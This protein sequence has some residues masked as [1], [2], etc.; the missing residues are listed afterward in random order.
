MRALLPKSD[1]AHE[2]V[3]AGIDFE[4]L[5]T[6]Y[7]A[8][9]AH[10]QAAEA[11]ENGDVALSF[12]ELVFEDFAVHHVLVLVDQGTHARSRA[13]VLILDDVEG[14]GAVGVDR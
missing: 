3:D 5:Q 9:D 11:D 10:K 12:I 1:L 4:V 6:L 7:F 13:L 2:E 14:V 8:L